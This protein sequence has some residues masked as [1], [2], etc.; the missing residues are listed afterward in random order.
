MTA[1]DL[2]RLAPC[3]ANAWRACMAHVAQ[4]NVARGRRHVFAWLGWVVRR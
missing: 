1:P 4:Q 3:T 2:R